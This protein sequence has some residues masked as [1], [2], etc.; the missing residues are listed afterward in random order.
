VNYNVRYVAVHEE[1]T[2]QQTY[3]FVGR[4]SAV[5][6]ADPEIVGRLLADQFAEEFGISGRDL[7]GPSA[8]AIEQRAQASHA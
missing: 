6:A 3:D 2:R 7:F 4:H 5:R 1:F 8:V